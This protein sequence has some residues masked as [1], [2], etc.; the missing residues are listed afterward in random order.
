MLTHDLPIPQSPARAVL[1]GASGFVGKTLAQRLAA[2]NIPTLGPVSRELDLAAPT[3]AEA[4]AALLRADDAVVFLAAL[5][6]DRGRDVATMMRNLEMG[7][8]VAVALERRPVAHVIYMS[9][10]AVYA[11]G[12]AP[13]D[14]ATPAVPLDLYGAMHRTRELIMAAAVKGP[15]AVL[16]STL[17][18]GAGDTH[19]S[20]GPNRFRRQAAKEGK[21]VLGGE[22]EETRDHIF[23]DDAAGLIERCLWRRTRGLANLVSGHSASFMEVARLVAATFDRPIEIV[24]TKRTAPVSHRRFDARVLTTA[25]PDFSFTALSD[26]LARVAAATNTSS[27]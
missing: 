5:T 11:F 3:A 12:D 26:G 23:V 10:D 8:N 4:L 25:F 13:I 1:L 2:A 20:Y 21:V 9:S 6:P 27:S 18:Y 7:R 15:L 19:N 22:G 17:V 16:R 14:E 24:T